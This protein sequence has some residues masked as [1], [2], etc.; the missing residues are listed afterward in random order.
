MTS[1]VPACEVNDDTEVSIPRADQTQVHSQGDTASL[2]N[3]SLLYCN[4][5]VYIL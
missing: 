5:S 3:V 1:N 2:P 4:P